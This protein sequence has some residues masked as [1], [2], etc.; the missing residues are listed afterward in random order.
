MVIQI[1]I[2][3]KFYKKKFDC[4]RFSTDGKRIITLFKNNIIGIPNLTNEKE[5]SHEI[6]IIVLFFEVT[7][8]NSNV[9]SGI[10]IL[11]INS[12]IGRT[13]YNK[14]TIF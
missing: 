7:F 3:F 14:F 10:E 13:R 8:R 6:G 1:K 11:H 5:L 9:F 12:F 4:A 2:I